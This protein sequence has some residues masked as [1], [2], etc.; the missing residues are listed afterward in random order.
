M[1]ASTEELNAIREIGPTVA[2]AVHDFFAHPQNQALIADLRA[3]GLTMPAEKRVTTIS[4]RG[5]RLC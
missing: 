3:C 5:L 2:E 1:A 4:W